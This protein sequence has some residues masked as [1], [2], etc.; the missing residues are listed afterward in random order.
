MNDDTRAKARDV[1]GAY[2]TWASPTT[3]EEFGEY[4]SWDQLTDDDQMHGRKMGDAV[5][6]ALEAAGLV[7]VD[8]LTKP[9]VIWHGPEEAELELSP[10]DR[11]QLARDL[12]ALQWPDS[13]DHCSQNLLRLEHWVER[14][15]ELAER[16]HI[17]RRAGR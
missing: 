2:F 5:L 11:G 17:T 12:C 10:E 6:A 4:P 13:P 16:W 7:V 15:S 1:I 8:T 9:V 14:A 3:G